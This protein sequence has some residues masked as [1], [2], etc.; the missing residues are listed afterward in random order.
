MFCTQWVYFISV[1]INGYNDILNLNEVPKFYA[2][3]ALRQFH[4]SLTKYFHY[5]PPLSHPYS[6]ANTTPVQLFFLL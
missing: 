4:V 5:D 6:L 2:I 1:L 3:K